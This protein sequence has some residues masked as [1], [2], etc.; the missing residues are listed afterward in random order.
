VT[1]VQGGGAPPARFRVLPVGS[2]VHVVEVRGRLDRAAAARLL[3]L[4]DARLRLVAL[5]QVATRRVVVDLQH[6]TELDAGAAAV[7]DRAHQTCRQQGV[8]FA[9]AGLSPVAIPLSARQVIGRLPTF[10]A[11]PAALD[12]R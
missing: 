8:A 9:L 12:T 5:G 3:R 4:V 7:L 11:V 6:A 1:T 2:D 10:P